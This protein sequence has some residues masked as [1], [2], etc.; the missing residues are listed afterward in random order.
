M[1]P[2]STWLA[3]STEL[4]RRRSVSDDARISNEELKAMVDAGEA[5]GTIEEQERELIYSIVEFGETTAREVMI[6]R[7]DMVG[8]PMSATMQIAVGS[9]RNSGHAPPPPADEAHR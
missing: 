8:L 1:A 9:N 3:R 5:Q 6:S 4:F 7:V 2:F